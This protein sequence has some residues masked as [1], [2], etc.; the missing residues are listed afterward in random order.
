MWMC[1]E[2]F[3]GV[4]KISGP[5]VGGQTEDRAHGIGGDRRGVIVCLRIMLW[6]PFLFMWTVERGII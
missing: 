5:S 6:F 1:L 3:R 2:R 4:G